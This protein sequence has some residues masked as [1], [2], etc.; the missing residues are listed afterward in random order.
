MKLKEDILDK[1]NIKIIKKTKKEEILSLYKE[2]GWWDED[3]NPKKIKGIIK[4]SL[5]FVAAFSENK[6]IGI[7]RVISDGVSDAY[8]QDV[9]VTKNQRGKGIGK[10]MIDFIIKYLK[11]RGISWIGLISKPEAEEFYYKLGF[12]PL[13]KHIPMKYKI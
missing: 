1:V 4:G 7:S 3:E 5:I 12:S 11:S 10:K 2:A 13:E 6:V 8:I 9:F